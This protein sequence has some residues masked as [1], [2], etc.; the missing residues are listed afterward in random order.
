MDVVIDVPAAHPVG[1]GRTPVRFGAASASQ[2][3]SLSVF[4]WRGKWMMQTGEEGSFPIKLATA[5][6][7]KLSQ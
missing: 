3:F 1:F 7:I 5:A 6:K 4:Q 2:F